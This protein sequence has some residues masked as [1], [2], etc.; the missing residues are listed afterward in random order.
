[1]PSPHFAPEPPSKL[2]LFRNGTIALSAEPQDQGDLIEEATRDYLSKYAQQVDPDADWSMQGIP[3][4][5]VSRSAMEA[6][7][8][9]VYRARL[10]QSRTR[11][12]QV[13]AWM[14]CLSVSLGFSLLI[15]AGSNF[16]T[17]TLILFTMLAVL[18]LGSLL[19][20]LGYYRK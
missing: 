17:G 18:P 11:E 15:L 1:M 13:P 20:H 12:K 2:R 16:A 10:A 14:R 9:E 8:A 5:I 3:I 7:W 6:T 19:L 4:C